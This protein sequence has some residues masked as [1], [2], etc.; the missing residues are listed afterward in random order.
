MSK[1]S[2]EELLLGCESYRAA[3]RLYQ[4]QEKKGERPE[5]K[6]AAGS[7]GIYTE[8][9]KE[10]VRVHGNKITNIPDA[11]SDDTTSVDIP[12]YETAKRIAVA[13]LSCFLFFL[14]TFFGLLL[15]SSDFVATGK[16]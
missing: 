7:F 9:P 14:L 10:K 3:E 6:D 8:Y 16:F 2:D 13:V 5:P 12:D 15:L 1:H 4:W 11:D